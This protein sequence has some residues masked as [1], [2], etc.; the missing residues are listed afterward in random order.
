MKSC[1]LLWGGSS[2]LTFFKPQ[3]L[4]CWWDLTPS[5][6]L[7]VGLWGHLHCRTVHLRAGQAVGTRQP[8]AGRPVQVMSAGWLSFSYRFS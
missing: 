8:R 1:P 5:Q 7:G 6:L 4:G 3:G 2:T